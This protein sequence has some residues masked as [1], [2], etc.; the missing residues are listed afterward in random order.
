MRPLTTS[1]KFKLLHIAN[2]I[3]AISGIYLAIASLQYYWFIVGLIFFLWAGIVGINVG[4][5]RYYS[6][7]SFKTESWKER[8]LLWSTILTSVGS[9]AM[10]CS[11]HRLH[12]STS[13]TD[14]DPHNPKFGM[15]KTWLGIWRP[16]VIPK[17]F[18]SPFLKTPELKFVHNNY[19]LIS[20]AFLLLLL[21]ID[22]RLAAF[23][24]AIPAVGCFH[25]AQCI[26][27]LPHIWGYRR[28]DTSDLSR[29]NWLASIMAL[30]EGW[31]NNHHANPGRWWQGETWWEFD[32]PAFMIKHFFMKKGT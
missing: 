10:W 2:H 12:H 13:D 22:V 5:H 14:S 11:I 21:I 9:P 25:G 3:V 18:I 32:P 4:L 8:I 15:L 28:Y 1:N 19:F 16:V 17:R 27:V 29:N 26:G 31:H 24:Y 30:G 20:F 6:H 7:R 23:V